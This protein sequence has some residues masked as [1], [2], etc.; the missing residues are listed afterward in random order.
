MSEANLKNYVPIP[1]FGPEPDIKVT[2]GRTSPSRNLSLTPVSNNSAGTGGSTASTPVNTAG[3]GGGGSGGG[4]V[5]LPPRP[6]DNLL[7]VLCVKN[8]ELQWVATEAC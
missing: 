4:G 5:G 1:V 8:T 3:G 6:N 2:A 7:Y